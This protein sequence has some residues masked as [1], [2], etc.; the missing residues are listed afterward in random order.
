MKSQQYCC[1][2]DRGPVERVLRAGKWRPEVL[3]IVEEELARLALGKP[4]YAQN[5]RPVAYPEKWLV[6]VCSDAQRRIE[7]LE[8]SYPH[9]IQGFKTWRL[10]KELER[11]QEAWAGNPANAAGVLWRDSKLKTPWNM[12]RLVLCEKRI[13]LLRKELEKREQKRLIWY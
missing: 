9:E 8:R 3:Q 4:L 11:E 6:S 2:P 13:Q 12:L 1:V 10:R 5:G 7:E